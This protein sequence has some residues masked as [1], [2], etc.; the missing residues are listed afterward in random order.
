MAFTVFN[1]CQAADAPK[2][3]ILREQGSNGD[4]EMAAA[5]TQAGFQVRG[6]HTRTL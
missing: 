2:V 5:F 1:L 4:R 3:A 6:P